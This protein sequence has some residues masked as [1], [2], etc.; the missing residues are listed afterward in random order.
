MKI[1]KKLLFP[2][3]IIFSIGSIALFSYTPIS[4]TINEIFNES[5]INEYSKNIDTIEQEDYKKILK[6]ANDYNYILSSDYFE[7]FDN[8]QYSETLK[9]YDNILNFGNGIICYLDIPKINVK[10]PVY[11]GSNKDVLTKGA[12]HLP[13][14][15][16]PVGGEST[17]A[18]IS[19]HSGYPAAKFFDDI[20]D[21]K[22]GDIIYINILNSKNKY[23]VYDTEVVDPED[24][25]HLKIEK[26]KDRLTLVT[27]YPY[28]INSHRL[29][30][31]AERT[32]DDEFTITTDLQ[33]Y[34]K[35]INYLQITIIVIVIVATVIFLIIVKRK[36]ISKL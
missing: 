22:T 2:L 20:D 33:N 3:L 19:A 15:S 13:E 28:G 14:T 4:N 34:N 9:N 5:K 10:L 35:S 23:T 27:C 17:H 26:N 7:N 16:L 21:L 32:S 8:S 30:V 12:A 11:H 18:V 24:T 25:S 29:L 1:L 36:L 31:H 6:E